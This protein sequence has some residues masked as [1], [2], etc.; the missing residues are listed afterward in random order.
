MPLNGF[1]R[2][3]FDGKDLDWVRKRAKLAD[4][5]LERGAA[6]GEG[7]FKEAAQAAKDKKNAYDAAFK[8]FA[9]RDRFWRMDVKK[10][11]AFRFRSIESEFPEAGNQHVHA[12]RVFGGDLGG[13]RGR[14]LCAVATC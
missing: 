1:L 14:L 9:V 4:E 8:A 7:K 2:R 6:K 5:E 3:E 10:E 13:R 11:G 12:A